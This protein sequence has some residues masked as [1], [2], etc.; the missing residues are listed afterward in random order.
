MSKPI[1]IYCP[2]KIL[3]FSFPHKF[4]KINENRIFTNRLHAQSKPS[5]VFISK[6]TIYMRI[7]I[8][9]LLLR[10]LFFFKYLLIPNISTPNQLYI[11]VYFNTSKI[12]ILVIFLSIEILQFVN[13]IS[14]IFILRYNFEHFFRSNLVFR[15]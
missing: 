7:C 15:L 6:V 9:F 2:F 10:T 13:I 5:V 14:P 3:F 11:L 4:L 8:N 12:Y 1:K